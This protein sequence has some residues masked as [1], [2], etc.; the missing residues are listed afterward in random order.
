MNMIDFVD[1]LKKN[2]INVIN[3]TVLENGDV[4]FIYKKRLIAIPK[5]MLDAFPKYDMNA[6]KMTLDFVRYGSMTPK[7]GK[8]KNEKKDIRTRNK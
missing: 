3:P 6:K 4:E 5:E 2:K 8:K 7:K 1:W